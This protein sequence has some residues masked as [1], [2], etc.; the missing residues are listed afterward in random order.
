[1][2]D[3]NAKERSESK[4]QFSTF[5]VPNGNLKGLNF[6]WLGFAQRPWGDDKAHPF[7]PLR[8]RMHPDSNPNRP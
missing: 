7:R 8:K 4:G 3:E 2:E 1:M 6:L 5:G